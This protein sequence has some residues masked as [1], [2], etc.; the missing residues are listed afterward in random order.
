MKH[1]QSKVLTAA[2]LAAL[3]G[4]AMADNP[5]LP[6]TK[7]PKPPWLESTTIPKTSTDSKSETPSTTLKMASLKEDQQ[8]KTMLK[9]M[10]SAVW[11]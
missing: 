11:V 10:T 2:I 9:P 3:S 6:L 4:S 1:F 8:Q 7:L 5:P